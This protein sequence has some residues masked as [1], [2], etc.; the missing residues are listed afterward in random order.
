M[1]IDISKRYIVEASRI[2]VVV[3]SYDTEEEAWEEA[4]R[5]IA[6]SNYSSVTFTDN[7]PEDLGPWLRD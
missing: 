2:E 7:H 6:D 4:R 1:G 5:L 3:K